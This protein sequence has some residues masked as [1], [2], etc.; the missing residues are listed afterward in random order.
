MEVDTS[1]APIVFSSPGLKEN[2]TRLLA[3]YQE[4]HV[5]Y[6][7]LKKHS[8][9]FRRLMDSPEKSNLVQDGFQYNWVTK[10][11]P[12]EVDGLDWHLISTNDY[13]G[14]KELG[15]D[16]SDL[17]ESINIEWEQKCFEALLRAFYEMPYQVE[18][19]EKM[20]SLTTMAD[21][22]CCCPTIS[23]TLNNAI[24]HFD[25]SEWYFNVQQ[26]SGRFLEL[27]IKLRNSTLFRD[28]LILHVGNWG[29]DMDSHAN[30]IDNRDLLKIVETARSKI[31]VLVAKVLKIGFEGKQ[32]ATQLLNKHRAMATYLGEYALAK[33]IRF[34]MEDST[35][36]N[37]DVLTEIRPAMRKLLDCKLA[38][39]T[40]C[41]A[42]S[43]NYPHH[44]LCAEI[45]D[46][47]LPWDTSAVDF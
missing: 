23:R 4:F 1:P 40:N 21:Y 33:H 34:I 14:K 27:A 7:I 45:E 20:K 22:Y 2:D 8:P 37:S 15:P 11:D 43:E 35:L 17:D 3:F 38:F 13:V 5:H 19:Y 30:W 12:L 47:E 18:S 28:A 39:G 46:D 26:N 9:H 31:A 25:N 24:F 32:G 6:S 16:P 29:D 41:V 36:D 44:F 42:G 10:I